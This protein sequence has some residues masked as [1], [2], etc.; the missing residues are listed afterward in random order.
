MMQLIGILML[1]GCAEWALI[2]RTWVSFR[3]L[4]LYAG[5]AGLRLY[6]LFT[7][8]PHWDSHYFIFPVCLLAVLQHLRSLWRGS[9]SHNQQT[10]KTP[11][12]GVPW[13]AVIAQNRRRAELL[14]HL[15]MGAF[16]WYMANYGRIV[17][18]PGFLTLS[19]AWRA[20]FMSNAWT[21]AILCGLGMLFSYSLWNVAVSGVPF[22]R[23]RQADTGESPYRHVRE[24][25]HRS[26][27]LPSVKELSDDIGDFYN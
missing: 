20:W 7:Y 5:I 10:Y 23:P 16:I 11:E 1:L 6:Y 27:R 21:F 12:T 19:P 22:F 4:L 18:A 24:E 3:Y 15:I 17:Y 14:E 26:P 13:L 2:F 25:S 8:F 9:T